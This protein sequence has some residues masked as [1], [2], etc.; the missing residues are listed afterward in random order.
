M[1][2][3]D[4]AALEQSPLAD[5][6][7]IASELSLDGYR[8]LRKAQ[9]ID[10]ILERQGGVAAAAGRDARRRRC[11]GRREPRP[12]R[13]PRPGVAGEAEAP[14]T[15]TSAATE[16]EPAGARRRRGRRGPRRRDHARGGAPTPRPRHRPRPRLRHR[17]R[18]PRPR[19][20][21]AAPPTCRGRGRGPAQRLGLPARQPARAL[22]RRRLHLGRPGQALRARL[23]RSH[24]PVPAARPAAPSASPRSCGW[25]PSTAARP[26]RWPTPRA[27]TICPPA[28]PV[29]RFRLASEDPTLK[30]IEFLTPFGRGSRVHDRRPG[31]GRARPRRCAGSPARWPAPRTSRS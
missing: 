26:A 5:L 13:S 12:A 9:L 28:F 19:A 25:T 2:I 11:L 24:Q 6:H 7:A 27:S 18:R 4:R 15:R 22:R 30:A 8:R 14:P 23:G 29:E 17:Q 1:S 10:A 20:R 16:A 21:D 31:P 3:L